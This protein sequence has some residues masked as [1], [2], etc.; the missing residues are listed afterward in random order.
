MKDWEQDLYIYRL[1]PAPPKKKDLQEYIALYLSEREEKYL[2]WFLH[3]YEHILN[4][5]AMAI[6]QDYAMQGHFID[7]KQAYVGGL[8][9]ALNA[10]DISH[11]VPFIIFKEYDAMGAVHD[12]IRT[13]RTGFTVQSAD[14]YL[15]LRKA[16]RLYGELGNKSDDETITQ[17]AAHIGTDEKTA[18]E[19]I[20]AGLQNTQFV[21]FYQKYADDE[22]EEETSEEVASDSTSEPDK[23]HFKMKRNEQL[24]DAFESLNYRERAVV[25]AH[26]GFCM[27]CYST[28]T[29]GYDKAG[30]LTLISCKPQS[31]MDIAIDHGLSSPDTADRI[32]RGALKKMKAQLKDFF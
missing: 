32:Y 14:E 8:L 23:L 31:F 7:I 29:L 13:M 9:K 18:R 12:Y 6:V 17:I 24:M 19:I 25:S 15:R 26:L 16:M 2:A 11:G 3:Y 20:T 28:R 27:V 22:E 21:D 10:Y 1:S 4:R 5:K 30:K